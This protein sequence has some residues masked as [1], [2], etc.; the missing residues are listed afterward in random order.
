[1]KSALTIADKMMN[2]NNKALD[3][4]MNDRRNSDSRDIQSAL[5]EMQ[6]IVEGLKNAKI[7]EAAK[8][9]TMMQK[10]IARAN[11]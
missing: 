1:M 7:P 6:I 9:E 8:Y 2:R 3:Y 10:Q 11:S 5:Y 4:Y